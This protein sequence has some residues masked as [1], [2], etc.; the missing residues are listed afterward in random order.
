MWSKRLFII[1]HSYQ[2]LN[3]HELFVILIIKR[4]IILVQLTITLFILI[5]T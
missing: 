1:K 5:I 2:N 3:V 4:N